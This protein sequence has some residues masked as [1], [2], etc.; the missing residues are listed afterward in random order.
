MALDLIR[1]T[2]EQARRRRRRS[3]AIGLLL[4]AVVALFYVL[5]VYRMTNGAVPVPS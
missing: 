1:L 2:P 3:L 5:A 4:A